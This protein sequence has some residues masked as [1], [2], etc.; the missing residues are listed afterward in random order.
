M[1]IPD[2]FEHVCEGRDEWLIVSDLRAPLLA[3]LRRVVAGAAGPPL[4]GGRG[5]AYVVDV[6]GLAVIVRPYR[7]G[8]LPRRFLHD[9][10]CSLAGSPRP[11]HELQIIEA[12]RRRDVPTI[13]PLAAAVRWMGW[14]R[15]RGWLVTRAVDGAQSLWQLLSCRPAAEVRRAALSASARAIARL[16]AAGASHPDLNFNNILVRG[17]QAWLI[18]F[19]RGRQFSTPAGQQRALARLRRSARKLD[20][21]GSIISDPEL[22][23]LVANAQVA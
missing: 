6:D 3:L 17:A 15:Y 14:R 9:T 5:G 11:F 18:D 13:E 19:D 10:Y 23:E 16:H 4:S 22:A 20:P 7:R 2:G 12:L 8:G 1:A 21:S